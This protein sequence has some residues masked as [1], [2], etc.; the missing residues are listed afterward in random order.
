MAAC[1]NNLRVPDELLELV[2]RIARHQRRT[3]DELA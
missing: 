1:E 2:Q 3:A